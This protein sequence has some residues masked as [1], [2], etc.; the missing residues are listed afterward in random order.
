[1][2][3]DTIDGENFRRASTSVDDGQHRTSI[4]T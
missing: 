4:S 1:V 3:I 2:S